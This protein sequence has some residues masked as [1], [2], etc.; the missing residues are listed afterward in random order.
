MAQHVKCTIGDKVY[1]GTSLADVQ[2]QVDTDAGAP[3]G[4][5]AGDG[6]TPGDPP[7]MPGGGRRRRRRTRRHRSRRHHGR[8]HRRRSRR[9]GK[10]SKSLTHHGDMNY[11]TKRGNKDFHRRHHDVKKSRRPYRKRRRSRKAR[12]AYSFF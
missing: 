2:T 4:E 5:T 11:T 10:G 8:R 3:S 12:G 7:S 6:H 9:H 1:T